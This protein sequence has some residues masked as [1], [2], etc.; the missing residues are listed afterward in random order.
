[1]RILVTNDDGVDAKGIAVLHRA[2]KQVWDDVVVVAPAGQKSAISHAITIHDPLR[3]RQ[4]GDDVYAVSG[5]PADCVLVALGH[6][7]ADSQPQLVLSGINQG[8]NLGL[9]VYYSGTVAGAREGLIQGIP[10]VAFSLV[11]PVTYPFDDIEPVVVHLLERVR[12][13]GVPRGCLL[14][15]NIPLPGT[16]QLAGPG[17]A[18]VAGIAG[19][20][21]TSLGHRAYSDEIIVREDP[22][23]R[24]YVWIGGSFPQMEQVDGT[25]CHAVLDGYVSVTPIELETTSFRALDQM[26]KAWDLDPD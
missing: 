3:A 6:L 12:D 18:G 20:R 5:T 19:V 2:A 25:D 15:V 13:E 24:P 21:V 23:G 4:L 11:G 22:R 8:P 17:L 1:M 10:A 7:C 9:D 16:A 14:N 26:M